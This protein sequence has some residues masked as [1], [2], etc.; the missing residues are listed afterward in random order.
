MEALLN[1][2]VGY[3]ILIPTIF[4]VVWAI[5]WIVRDEIKLRR[6]DRQ[7]EQLQEELDSVYIV[8]RMFQAGSNTNKENLKNQLKIAIDHISKKR[9]K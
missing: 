3:K 4:F 9:K 7:I 5:S 2:Q 1:C 8:H 6:K